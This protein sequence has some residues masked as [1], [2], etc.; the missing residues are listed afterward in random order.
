MAV[1][2]IGRPR[3]GDGAEIRAAAD[4]FLVRVSQLRTI[5]WPFLAF[6]ERADA[7]VRRVEA[8]LAT[9]PPSAPAAVQAAAVRPALDEIWPEMS[10]ARLA[11]RVREAVD[12]LQAAIDR[13]DGRA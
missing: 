2:P 8:R 4:R 5:G 10:G 12:A 7:T 11:S 3:T 9:L 6:E 13:A 1:T